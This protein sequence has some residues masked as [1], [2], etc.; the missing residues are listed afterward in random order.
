MGK[1][2]NVWFLAILLVAGGA[3]LTTQA[4]TIYGGDAGDLVS[5]IVTRGIAHPPGYPLYTF[6][7]TFVTKSI[8]VSTVAWRVAF[9]SSI[10]AVVTII[11]LFD[12]LYYLSRRLFPS[13]VTSLAFAF[14][15]PVWL[16]ASV[17]EVFSLNNLFTI[18]LL[19]LLF[20]WEKEG[21]RKY[22]LLASF[23]FGLSLTHHHIILFLLPSLLYLFLKRR[24]EITGKLLLTS[25]L[26]FF[27]GLSPYLYVFLA[28]A[29][30]PGVNWMG[31]P[32]LSPFF[33][34]VT[35]AGYGTF[36]A[37][38]FI[39]HEPV[40]RIIDIFAFFDFVYKDF[41]ILGIILFLFGAF[42]LWKK[43]KT[44]FT[45]LLL[46]LC[47]Y[48]F[49]LFYA[50]FPLVENFLVGTFERFVQPLYIIIALFVG[51]GL[52]R[53]HRIFSRLSPRLARLFFTLFLIYP[54][55]LFILNYPKIHILKK[56]MT[57]ENLGRD[58]L[59]SIPENSVL[60]I[61]TDTPLFNTQ[62][63]YYTEKRWE[64]IKLVHLA[65]LFSP[66]YYELFN[67]Q[68]PELFLPSEQVSSKDLF[69]EFIRGN[70]DKFPIYS[71]LAFGGSEGT[72]VPQGLL[73]R[74][75]KNAELPP[76][77]TIMSEN[78]KVWAQYQDPLKGSLSKYRNLLLSDVLRVY[79]IARQESGFWEAKQG[80]FSES[81][82]HLQEGKRLDPTDIDSYIIL[83]QVYLSSK[84]CDSA[85]NEI[86]YV[87]RI[88]D[89]P[90]GY[91]LNS[92]YA[93]ICLKDP[94]KASL[95]QKLFDG[96]TRGKETSLQ[97]L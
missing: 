30:R 92:L 68:Y 67:A 50:S 1:R 87:L 3:Y 90:R 19:W 57:A 38:S 71:K 70:Y 60:I 75:Y 10:P 96:S 12:L 93:A 62:Y 74:Y 79:A 44:I 29:A 84:Q 14:L 36:R 63:V 65:K 9:L 23:V 51:F 4:E 80:F 16:Y 37:G 6:L 28:A 27:A 82:N 43:E 58:I 86:Q 81:E 20:H 8:P 35:R 72:W 94:E 2:W 88:A 53:I 59:N 21:K 41:R 42:F 76:A 77:K 52:V 48:L 54:L 26:L 61:S 39:A 89:E 34:L 47:S 73:F 25:S 95:Y 66:Y 24:K 56:D 83:S 85:H 40:L 31:P 55:G 17:V 18:T 5:A 97:K 78:E 69:Q 64:S 33:Q 32:A 22:I 13:L 45:T 11:F 7:G 49:F 15:Y 46:G 91:L